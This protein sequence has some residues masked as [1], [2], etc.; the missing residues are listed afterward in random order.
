M[1][2][3]LG[4]YF[5]ILQ[6]NRLPIKNIKRQAVQTDNG[7]K[8]RQTKLDSTYCKQDNVRENLK[9]SEIIPYKQKSETLLY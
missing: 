8:S 2:H 3:K 4:N 1:K 5:S 7:I 6:R 9:S